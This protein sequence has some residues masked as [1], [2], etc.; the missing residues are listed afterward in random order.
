MS[1]LFSSINRYRNRSLFYILL[2]F[3]AGCLFTGLLIFGFGSAAVGKLNQRYAEQHGR[4]AETIGQLE[5]QLERERQ[6]NRQ[7]RDYNNRARELTEGLTESAQRNVRNLQDA[8]NLIGEIRTKV[9]V[10]AEFYTNSD[11]GNGPF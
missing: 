9:K 8:V 7:L 1:G 6:L 4:A 11:S 3:L 2:A 10:L 5:G